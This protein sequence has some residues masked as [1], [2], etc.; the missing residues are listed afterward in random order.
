M[1][2]AHQGLAILIGF[3]IAGM[4]SGVVQAVVGRASG[5]ANGSMT[6]AIAS[7]AGPAGQVFGPPLAPPGLPGLPGLMPGQPVFLIFAAM[8]GASM[9]VLPVLRAP[10]K[11][12]RAE[13]AAA[14]G[15]S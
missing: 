13:P 3:G 12:R 5:D 2:L 1:P 4:G 9:P 10:A 14:M 11:A 8:I 6:M 7:A 15:T